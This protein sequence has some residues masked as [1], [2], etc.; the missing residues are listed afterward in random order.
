VVEWAAWSPDGTQIAV[1]STRYRMSGDATRSFITLVDVAD[2]STTTLV[3]TGALNNV[4]ISGMTWAPDSTRL[5]VIAQDAYAR[6]SDL[7][8]VPVDGGP[9]TSLTHR[10]TW[11]GWSSQCDNSEP[12]DGPETDLDLSPDG[13]T[14]LAVDDR[15]L[16]KIDATTLAV[17]P[18]GISG[19][20]PR[21]SPDG[22]RIAYITT[23]KVPGVWLDVAYTVDIDGG[24]RTVATRNAGGVQDWQPCTSTPCPTFGTPRGTMRLGEVTSSRST[25]Y[26]N[27]VMT[28]L[29]PDA[30]RD[31]LPGGP[32]VLQRRTASGWKAKAHATARGTTDGSY[33]VRL[34]RPDPGKC[35]LK[36]SFPGDPWSEPA[37]LTTPSMRC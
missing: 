16:V 12:G 31:F 27:V 21:W 9:V 33:K 29:P 34:P 22:T 6:V 17:S 15:Q 25:E 20:S 5:A 30:E 13:T 24:D 1:E 28:V 23:E 8:W 4:I 18:L 26:L 10:C 3:D 14:F 19:E 37:T 32:V 36:F 11:E 35:R 7:R 2:G